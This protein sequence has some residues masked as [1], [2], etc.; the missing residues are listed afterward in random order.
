MCGVGF[1]RLE[2]VTRT[3]LEFHVSTV[4]TVNKIT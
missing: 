2:A 3:P 4:V 1:I